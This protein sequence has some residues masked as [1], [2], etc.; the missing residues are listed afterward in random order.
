MNEKILDKILEEAGKWREIALYIKKEI[1]I[2]REK[3]QDNRKKYVLLLEEL[4]TTWN[5]I[6][7][8]IKG[9]LNVSEKEL[10]AMIEDQDWKAVQE[11]KDINIKLFIPDKVY[12]WFL[13]KEEGK[14]KI[15][16]EYK[17]YQG[18]DT[19]ALLT[20]VY[21]KIRICKE[22]AD[23]VRHWDQ[24]LEEFTRDLMVLMRVLTK[25]KGSVEES[26]KE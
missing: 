13:P 24:E 4:S 20:G 9:S 14:I 7:S 23:M 22:K 3:F 18:M 11:D 16:K 21:T 19:V 10:F 2:A 1:D 8:Y 15:S 26:P 6:C 17:K 12:L 25:T 5:L